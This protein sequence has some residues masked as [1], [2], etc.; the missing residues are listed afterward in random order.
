MDVLVVVLRDL[1]LWHIPVLRHVLGDEIQ[2][3]SLNMVLLQCFTVLSQCC[4]RDG[5]GNGDGNDGG[6]G[7]CDA[8]GDGDG[9][10]VVIGFGVYQLAKRRE[11]ERHCTTIPRALQWWQ[12]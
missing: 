12:C 6:N 10:L 2:K 1:H 11:S 7:D 5:D 3:R 8:D 4:H 9:Y